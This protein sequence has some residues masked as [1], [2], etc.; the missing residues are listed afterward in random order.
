MSEK[1]DFISVGEP[2]PRL[3]AVRSAHDRSVEVEW[4]DGTRAIIDLSPLVLTHKAFLGLQD[5]RVFANVQLDD[6]GWGIFWPD[7]PDAA[8]A[9]TTLQQLERG[10]YGL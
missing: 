1:D 6:W 8:I 5:D 7:V 2:I 3:A 9:N 4:E 10:E